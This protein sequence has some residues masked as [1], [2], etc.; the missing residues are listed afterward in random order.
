[1]TSLKFILVVFSLNLLAHAEKESLENLD[2]LLDDPAIWQYIEKRV[3][4]DQKTQDHQSIDDESLS[5]R[6]HFPFGDEDPQIPSHSSDAKDVP[7]NPPFQETRH[8]KF[9]YFRDESK[10]DKFPHYLHKT[11][12]DSSGNSC[13]YRQNSSL[14]IR[15]KTSLENGAAFLRNANH[16]S[17]EECARKCCYTQNCNLAVYEDKVY[18]YIKFEKR[19]RTIIKGCLILFS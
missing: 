15:S 16:L 8:E 5:P 17:A 3:Q 12:S 6:S 9:P 13:S 7:E 19:G 10:T 4:Q 1:M 18:M 2:Q 14:I 11:I